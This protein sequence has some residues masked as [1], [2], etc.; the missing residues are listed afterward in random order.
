MAVVF[1]VWIA[2][3]VGV[4]AIAAS[5]GRSG[6][7]LFFASVFLSPLIGF[8]IVLC[9]ANRDQLVAEGET[10]AGYRKCPFC[11]E[12]VRAEAIK[13]KHCGS[14][15]PKVEAPLEPQLGDGAYAT[16]KDDYNRAFGIEK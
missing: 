11:A 3:C 16:N 6:I 15:L 10:V 2:L 7:G 1:L 9:M 12:T 4:G 13:C 5:K 8:I 14:D